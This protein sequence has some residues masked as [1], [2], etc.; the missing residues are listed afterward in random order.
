[1]LYRCEPGISTYQQVGAFVCY[2][3][4]MFEESK[5]AVLFVKDTYG[6]ALEYVDEEGVSVGDGVTVIENGKETYRDVK[7][8][9]YTYY[10]FQDPQAIVYKLV[11]LPDES[12]GN[13]RLIQSVI[14]EE[15]RDVKKWEVITQKVEN[16]NYVLYRLVPFTVHGVPTYS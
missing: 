3:Y 13:E 12:V 7:G 9:D 8:G 2:N 16:K 1:L 15:M 14:D 11:Y 10:D 5:S 4:D 6:I